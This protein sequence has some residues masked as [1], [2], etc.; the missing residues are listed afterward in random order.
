MATD[1]ADP[2]GPAREARPAERDVLTDWMQPVVDALDHATAEQVRRDPFQRDP[3]VVESY[4]P[5]FKAIARYF[6]TE[7]RGWEHLPKGGPCL[8]VGNHSGGAETNDTA[9]IMARW[10]EDRGPDAPL[11]GLA[12]DLLFAYPVVGPM[13]PKLGLLPAS[14]ENGQRAL[15]RGAAV[16]VFP[17]GDNEV[18]RPWTHR[19]RI[20]FAG[21]KGFVTLAIEAGVPVIPMTIHG[22]HS[23][24]FV[25][26]RGDGIAKRLGITRLRVKVFPVIVNI[27]FGITPA[28]VPSLQLPA[29]VTI[30]LGE[31]LDWSHYGPE[32]ATDPDVLQRCYD[33]ITGIMQETM[34]RLAKEHPYPILERLNALRPGH[35]VR[36]YL[37]G[38]KTRRADPK[39]RLPPGDTP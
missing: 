16:I 32:R 26:T 39:R 35:L 12:Y 15:E 31:P 6:D 10:I 33:E 1:P 21:H 37:T 13:L 9:A 8:I 5:Y 4:L 14:H 30:E 29:K 3:R 20:E 27:P 36:R 18:F 7:I 2:P 34:D 19:N 23:S 25:L 28:F 38:R 17:G 22:A 11:Y 24:T